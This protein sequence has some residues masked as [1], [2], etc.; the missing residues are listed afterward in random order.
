MI[1]PKEGL[2]IRRPT[3]SEER[4]MEEESTEGFYDPVS[5]EVVVRHSPS[6][7]HRKHVLAH[8]LGHS[9]HSVPLSYGYGKLG[10]I[11][12]I[13]LGNELV[14]DYYALVINP[15]DE[16]AIS[17]IIWLRHQAVNSGTDPA[18]VALKEKRAIRIVGYKGRPVRR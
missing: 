6:R 10:S 5:R 4:T 18:I 3:P 12:L 1:I 11:K 2:S 8:E 14:A 13:D 17:N 16:E 7:I 15:G 9:R